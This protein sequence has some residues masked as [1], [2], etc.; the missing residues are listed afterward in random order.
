M[1]SPV[2]LPPRGSGRLTAAPAPYRPGDDVMIHR[3]YHAAT[4]RAA[5]SDAVRRMLIAI[6][7]AASPR[8]LVATRV[9][10]SFGYGWPSMPAIRRV[11][12]PYR[13]S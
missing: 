4:R 13:Y 7:L 3:R 2:L 1:G 6:A 12:L 9:A 8:F 5:R 10:N 11:L